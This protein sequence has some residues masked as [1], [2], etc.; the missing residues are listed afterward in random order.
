MHP[1]TGELPPGWQIGPSTPGASNGGRPFYDERRVKVASDGTTCLC[2]KGGAPMNFSGIYFA[3]PAGSEGHGVRPR[4]VSFRFA[5]AEPSDR[6]GFLDFLFSSAPEP[7]CDVQYLFDT[8]LQD[9]FGVVI[10]IDDLCSELWLPSQGMLVSDLPADA[11]HRTVSSPREDAN[12]TGMPG[13]IEWHDVSIRL[14]WNTLNVQASV[15]GQPLQMPVCG[16]TETHFSDPDIYLV[17]GFRYLYLYTWLYGPEEEAMASGGHRSN[18]PE[19]LIS[20][21]WLEDPAPPEVGRAFQSLAPD[22]SS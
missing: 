11:N 10:S 18:P 22:E 15:N 6:S 12:V 20:D 9:V 5:V 8:D 3:F 19:I 14:D 16:A 7:Y 2:F 21:V 13:Q 17:R 1:G 4:R